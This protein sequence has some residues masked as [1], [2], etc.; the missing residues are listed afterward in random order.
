M[1]I[2][3]ILRAKEFSPNSVEK[4]QAI[5]QAV[6]RRLRSKGYVAELVNEEELTTMQDVPPDTTVLSMGRMSR[7]L[8]WLSVQDARVI[9]SPESVIQCQSR[10]ALS[11]IMHEN[12]VAQPPQTG[13][14]GYWLKRDCAARQQGDVVFAKNKEELLQKE[15]EF[16]RRGITDYTRSVPMS[17]AMSSSS[18]GSA[19]QAFSASTIPPLMVTPNLRMNSITVPLIIIHSMLMRF[20]IMSTV[21]HQ[22]LASTSTVAMRLSRATVRFASS[23]SMTGLV[24]P[25]VAKRLPAL[26]SH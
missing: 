12:G 15:A 6:V 3:A 2:L 19:A 16:G 21:W 26:S 8:R 25:D 24:S 9:N 14:S 23:I 13:D 5:M 10:K 11:R 17:K 1:K 20:I 22:L 7:T 4:D 18:T